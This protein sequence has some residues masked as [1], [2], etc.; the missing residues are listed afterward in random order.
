MFSFYRDR[1][2]F[3]ANRIVWRKASMCTVYQKNEYLLY[4]NQFVPKNVEFLRIGS[5]CAKKLAETFT[6]N[7]FLGFK[8]LETSW[9]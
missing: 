9:R 8:K 5:F 2:P 1:K 7:V 3:R 6:R 4:Q